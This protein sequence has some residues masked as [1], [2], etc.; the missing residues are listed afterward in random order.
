M[1]SREVSNEQQPRG[2]AAA[3]GRLRDR[4]NSARGYV[5]RR[6]AP[7]VSAGDAGIPWVVHPGGRHYVGQDERPATPED[8]VADS[9]TGAVPGRSYHQVLPPDLA[10]WYVYTAPGGHQLMIH[11]AGIRAPGHDPAAFLVLVPV[12]TVLRAGWRTEEGVI[13]SAVPFRNGPVYSRADVER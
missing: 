5:A 7:P 2:P 10:P 3:A 1:R 12:R 4:I 9:V 11:P 13:V 8:V 6:L